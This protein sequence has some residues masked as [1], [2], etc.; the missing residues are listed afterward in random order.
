MAITQPR[1]VQQKRQPTKSWQAKKTEPGINKHLASCMMYKL[2]MHVC[3]LLLRA[4]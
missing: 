4:S 2:Y 3:H 1:N